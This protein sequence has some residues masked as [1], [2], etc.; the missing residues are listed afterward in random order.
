M[1]ADGD[2]GVNFIKSDLLWHCF[3]HPA[4]LQYSSCR[5]SYEYKVEYLLALEENYKVCV[6]RL[7]VT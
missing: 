2:L 1:D 6:V 4:Y 3:D 5:Y 7:Y